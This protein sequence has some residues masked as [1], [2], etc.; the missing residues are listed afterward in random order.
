MKNFKIAVLCFAEGGRRTV[1]VFSNPPREF[2][3]VDRRSGSRPVHR[4]F[5]LSRIGKPP[6][7]GYDEV[8]T[9]SVVSERAGDIPAGGSVGDIPIGG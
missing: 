5:K 9:E 7:I 4:Y 6:F 3:F 2:L 8:A 1:K